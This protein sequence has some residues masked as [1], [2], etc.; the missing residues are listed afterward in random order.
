MNQ[1]GGEVWKED[2]FKIDGGEVLHGARN[3]EV[4]EAL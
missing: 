2:S 4:L 1:E 3:E